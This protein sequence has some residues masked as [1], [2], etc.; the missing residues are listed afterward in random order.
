MVKAPRLRLGELE[1]PDDDSNEHIGKADSGILKIS[2]SKE[3]FIKNDD[4]HIARIILR[5]WVF[6]KS[7]T[8]TPILPYLRGNGRF[9]GTPWQN[10]IPCESYLL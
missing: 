6:T 5:V 3:G 2:D 7:E 10:V 1:V 8:P 9:A 4:N